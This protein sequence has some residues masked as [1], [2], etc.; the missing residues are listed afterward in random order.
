MSGGP[1]A[2]GVAIDHLSLREF[3]EQNRGVAMIDQYCAAPKPNP[4][5]IFDID[6]TLCAAHGGR[7]LALRN[8]HHE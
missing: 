1:G 2:A 7:P 4:I 3:D 5:E 6:D 8:A